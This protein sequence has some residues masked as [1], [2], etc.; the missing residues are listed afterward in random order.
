MTKQFGYLL[1][2]FLLL[3]YPLHSSQKGWEINGHLLCT[4]DDISDQLAFYDVCQ[5]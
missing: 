4:E 5:G 1:Y 2:L 3:M